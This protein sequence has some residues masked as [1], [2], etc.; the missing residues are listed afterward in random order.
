MIRYLAL[1]VLL[2][3]LAACTH[4][5][6]TRS[7]ESAQAV[8]DPTEFGPPSAEFSDYQVNTLTWLDPTGAVCASTN[9]GLGAINAARSARDEAIK[10]G[11]TSYTYEYN[12]HAPVAGLFC[13]GYYR[14]GSGRTLVRQAPARDAVQKKQD[15]SVD[16]GLWELGFHAEGIEQL[17]EFN[18]VTYSFG[19]QLAVGSYDWLDEEESKKGQIKDYDDPILFRMPFWVGAGLFPPFLFGFGIEAEGG[20]DLIAWALTAKAGEWYQKFDYDVR[21]TYQLKE[22]NP[23]VLGLSAGLKRENLHWGTYWMVRQGPYVNLSASYVF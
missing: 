21:A 3:G 6:Y 1:L 13:G 7:F 16:S 11:Q 8:I 15:I 2:C 22:F 10:K 18:W 20:V 5:E 23:F 19:F 12:L 14:F 4:V 9:T 17:E